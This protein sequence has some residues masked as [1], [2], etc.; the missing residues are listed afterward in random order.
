MNMAGKNTYICSD[1]GCVF[2]GKKVIVNLKERLGK[3]SFKSLLQNPFKCL[4]GIISTRVCPECGSDKVVEVDEKMETEH[5][6][7]MTVELDS[8]LFEESFDLEVTS[9]DSHK[10]KGGVREFMENTIRFFNGKIN[11]FKDK[12]NTSDLMGKVAAVA[13]KAGVSTVYHALLLYYVLT[14]N[15]IPTNKKVIV[16]A[17]LGYFIAPVDFIPDFVLMGLFD[18][19]SVLLFA[20][21]QI[22]PYIT[23]EDKA[24]ALAKLHDWFGETEIM[25]VRSELLPDIQNKETEVSEETDEEENY[26]DVGG[27][28]VIKDTDIPEIEENLTDFD[29]NE[30]INNQISKNMEIIAPYKE[31]CD[32]VAERFNQ[33]INLAYES[34]KEVKV[35]YIK[36]VIFKDMSVSVRIGIEEVKADSVLLSYDVA[37]C[38]DSIISGVISF[39]AKK[40]PELSAGIH[41]EDNH[42]IRINLSEIEKARPV[43]ENIELRSITPQDR[44]LRIEFGLKVPKQG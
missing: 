13:K 32:Y 17:A 21:N 22:M 8:S 3:D 7:N 42:R 9:V 16:M 40:F 26:E 2:E 10:G 24:K 23:D 41:P 4:S 35:S 28:E 39:I 6:E 11:E 43:V 25:S 15:N 18:D 29:T 38:I 5:P 14:G 33:S 36:H 12:Y 44:G 1:C 37:F 31:I 20:L 30:N 19:G 34:E 27:V